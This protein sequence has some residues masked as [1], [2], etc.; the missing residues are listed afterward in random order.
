VSAAPLAGVLSV[1]CGNRRCHCLA[2]RAVLELYALS[3]QLPDGI[4]GVHYAHHCDD[5]RELIILHKP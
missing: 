3:A 5:A 1:A 2:G 4:P